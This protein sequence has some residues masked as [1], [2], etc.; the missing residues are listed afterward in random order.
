M[1]ETTTVSGEK[2]LLDKWTRG[3]L[4]NGKGQDECNRI[5]PSRTDEA[6]SLHYKNT[7]KL[8]LKLKT[9]VKEEP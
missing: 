9:L 6:I 4:L 5:Y 8:E 2:M 3:A 7:D 1:L